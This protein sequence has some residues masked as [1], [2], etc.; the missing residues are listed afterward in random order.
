MAARGV[1]WI[2]ESHLERKYFR[3]LIKSIKQTNI[4]SFLSSK[5]I[6]SKKIRNVQLNLLI[7]E[8]VKPAL[9]GQNY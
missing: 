4:P 3:I 2:K 6:R 1:D 7:T 9:H 8:N 5:R